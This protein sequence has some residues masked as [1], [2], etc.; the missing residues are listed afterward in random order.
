VTT[1]ADQGGLA[2]DFSRIPVFPPTR[3]LIQ[4]KLT[5][6]APGDAYEHEADRVTEQVMR[7]PQP[8]TAAVGPASAPSGSAPAVQRE[9]ACGGSC[10]DCKKKK[11]EG[12]AKVQ[13]K[14]SGPG[15]AGGM[16]APPIVHEVLRS[17]GQPLDGAT[18]A[19]MEPRFGWDFSSVRVHT[20]EKAAE[21]AKAVGA[22][23][24]T[25]GSN[26]VFGAGEFAPGKN[27]GQ[28]LLGHEL[29]HV[30]QQ[31][32][33]HSPAMIQRR[34]VD[35]R[36]CAGLKD[37]EAD[38]DTE[39]KK[40]IDDARKAPGTAPLYYK[41]YERLGK[42]PLYISPIESFIDNLGPGKV[43]IPPS[44]LAGTKYQGAEKVNPA[45]ALQGT[46]GKVVA[47]TASVHN[48]C[49]G[50][51][52]LGHFF[53]LGAYYYQ[54][55][56]GTSGLT[57]KDAESAGR[58]KEIG[59][60]GLSLSGVFSNADLAAN[61]AGLKFYQDLE[62]NPGGYAFQIK[63]YITAQWNEKSNPNFYES[64]LAGVVWANLLNGIWEGPL[65]S[66]GKTS[67]CKVNLTGSP[68]QVTGNYEWP[69]GSKSPERGT[70][71]NGIITQKTTTVSGQGFGA[72]A[73]SDTAVSGISIEFEWKH[74]KNHGKGLW[75]SINEQELEGTWGH[76]KAASGGGTWKLKKV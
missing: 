71:T 17:S 9:C 14:A 63:N 32:V 34:E 48:I 18:R 66:D 23:A 45:Y 35:D 42:S 30:V 65:L 28:R 8:Q 55:L 57:S 39:V 1:K 19:F 16:E 40:Q 73:V 68:T 13:M 72:S 47:G 5:V 21:S 58:A 26:V 12:P 2:H 46:T 56:K 52:K 41:V 36:S 76:G 27:E 31:D 22:R 24:Y 44:D 53:E 60:Q 33:G 37:I 25:V 75:N 74:G 20:D 59:I 70:I 50:S 62:A 4:R 61:L 69:T 67:N 11:H 49:V 15:S 7:M 38:V 64:K 51:D 3:L 54:N 6:N 10:E 29:A 43:K